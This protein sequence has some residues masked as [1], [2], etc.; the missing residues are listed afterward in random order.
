MTVGHRPL[1]VLFIYG[2]RVGA[3][4]GG[5]G[6]RAVELAR[7]VQRELGAEVTIAAADSDGADVGVPVVLFRPHAPRALDP[8][9]TRADAIVAQP[10]WPLL[11]RRLR[12]SSARLVFDLYDPEVFGTLE[13]FRGRKPALRASMGAFAA[14]RLTTS[15]HIGHHLMCA[16]ERQRDLWLGAMLGVG[17]ITSRLWDKDPSF[18]SFLDVVPYG[19]PHEPPRVEPSEAADVRRRLGLAGEDELVLWNGGIWSWLDAPAAIEAIALLR[20]RRPRAQLV[21]MGAAS[22]GPA[23][24]ATTVARE[25]ARQRGLIGQGVIFND[26]WVPYERRAAWLA[27]AD[28]AISTHLDHLETR[29]SSRTRLLDCFWARLPIVCTGG[30][31]LGVRVEREG[32]GEVVAPGDY[33]AIADALERV[34]GAGRDTYAPALAGAATNLDWSLVAAPLLAW[35]SGESP[36]L[37]LGERSGWKRPPSER[38]RSGAYLLAAGALSMLRV[39][40]PSLR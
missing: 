16:T 20:K 9:L 21:F 40:P 30:D 37:R 11:M 4:M 18:C 38:L 7:V 6:I 3:S 17:L 23:L 31:E 10:G 15:L 28:C 36:A 24:E 5:V 35:L 34:L 27:T 12:R 33:A 1:K 29:F 19:V 13:N 26:E 8:Y 14:D 32:L 22:A 25:L 2:D 39:S